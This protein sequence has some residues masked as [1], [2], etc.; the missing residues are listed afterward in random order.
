MRYS[1]GHK[2]VYDADTDETYEYGEVVDIG[3]VDVVHTD[4]RVNPSGLQADCLRA[5]RAVFR[6]MCMEASLFKIMSQHTLARRLCQM[7]SQVCCRFVI[8]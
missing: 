8:I 5:L 2:Q 7:L 6:C 3:D 1:F 4:L